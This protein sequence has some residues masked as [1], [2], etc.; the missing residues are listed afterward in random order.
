LALIGNVIYAA[1]FGWIIAAAYMAAAGVLWLSQVGKPYAYMCKKLAGYYLWPFGKYLTVGSTH[2]A[3]VDTVRVGKVLT[4]KSSAC[5]FL[6]RGPLATAP[7]PRQKKVRLRR[8]VP[9]GGHA[10]A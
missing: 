4:P 8:D 2:G 6:P 1:L 10:R 3:Y 5:V 7:C 9:C